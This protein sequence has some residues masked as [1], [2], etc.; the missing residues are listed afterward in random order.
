MEKHFRGQLLEG[1]HVSIV[2]PQ[3]DEENEERAT[4]FIAVVSTPGPP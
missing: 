4:T 1:D 2:V 3:G